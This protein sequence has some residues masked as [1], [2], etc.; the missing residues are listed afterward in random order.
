M[1]KQIRL[2]EV[3]VLY[4]STMDCVPVSV[5]LPRHLEQ[6]AGTGEARICMH[7]VPDLSFQS[8]PARPYRRDASEQWLEKRK[9]GLSRGGPVGVEEEVGKER[10]DA[11][12]S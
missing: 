4:F 3:C 2:G 8:K 12:L 11:L 6:V 7:M 5:A 9:C 10:Q 1:R